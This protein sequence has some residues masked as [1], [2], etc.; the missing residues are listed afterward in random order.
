MNNALFQSDFILYH[1]INRKNYTIKRND[2]LIFKRNGSLHIKRCIGLP[3][4]TIEVIDNNTI[5]INGR[6]L[7]EENTVEKKMTK[8]TGYN[9]QRKEKGIKYDYLIIP[10]KGFHF[11]KSKDNLAK[12]QFLQVSQQDNISSTNEHATHFLNG[13][14]E[15]YQF[16]NNYYFLMGDNRNFSIDSRYYGPVN[17]EDI[18]GK[19]IIKF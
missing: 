9:T 13:S 16:K 15:S 17:E 1:S 14:N 6:I 8:T 4:D 19:Y 7:N 18:I 10:E 5:K 3:G 11:Q 12:Y 2:I